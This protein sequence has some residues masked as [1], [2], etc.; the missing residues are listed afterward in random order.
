MG[1]AVQNLTTLHYTRRVYNG[2]FLPNSSLPRPSAS[3]NPDDSVQKIVPVEP[4]DGR[5]S[6]AQDQ[7]TPLAARL[8]GN[9]TFMAGL[10]RFY[11]SYQ[12]ED[13]YLYQLALWTH[14]IAV[15]HF[16]SEL[17]LYKSM[18]FSGPQIFPLIA[19][20]LGTVWMLMQWRHY[21]A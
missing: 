12:L 15:A 17:L 21:V 6:T 10:I 3:Y 8:F 11:A 18:R 13:P 9:Y 19:G 1:N 4:G 16:T 2:R 5:I 14:L 20:Y 7:I